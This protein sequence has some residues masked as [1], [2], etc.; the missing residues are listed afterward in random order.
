MEQQLIRNTG[1]KNVFIED[2]FFEDVLNALHA[3]LPLPN[4]YVI[5]E[6]RSRTDGLV[7][8]QTLITNY[9]KEKLEQVQYRVEIRFEPSNKDPQEPFAQYCHFTT[10]AT[11]VEE[12]FG[13]YYVGKCI[14][15]TGWEDITE[16]MKAELLRKRKTK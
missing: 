11:D 4:Y 9:T 14:D 6:D 3:L 5:L 7:F 10:V 16:E 8:I 13:K 1:A 2:P 12:L 15:V